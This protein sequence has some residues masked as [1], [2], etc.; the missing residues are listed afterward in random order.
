MSQIHWINPVDGKFDTAA[1]WSGGVVP[2]AHVSA[3]LD[4][5]GAAFQVS[6]SG[7]ETVKSIKLAANATLDITGGTFQ[8][9]NATGVG[10]GANAG[11]I[12]VSGGSLLFGGFGQQIRTANTGLIE[13]GQRGIVEIAGSAITGRSGKITALTGG[14]FYLDGC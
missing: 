13:A 6:A 9:K 8:A 2:G 4:A 14:V 1:D 10:A 7:D 3:I 11:N 5:A 12:L